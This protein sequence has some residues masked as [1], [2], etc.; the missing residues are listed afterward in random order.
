MKKN[1]T[2]KA[3][4]SIVITTYKRKVEVISKSIQ[5]VL[6]QTYRALE[7]IIVDDSPADYQERE[8]VKKYC[9]GL[10]DPRVRYVQQAKNMG[11]CVAR[12]TGLEMANGQLI[13]FL[14]DD[15]E[16][17]PERIE[18]M[19]PYFK[20]NV[21]LVYSNARII[22]YKKKDFSTTYF[23]TGRQYQ[24]NVYSKIM[25]NNFVGSTS[26]AMLKTEKLRQVGG[27]DPEMPAFQDWDVWIRMSKEG[28]F[29]YTEEPLVNYYIYEGERITNNTAKRLA[30]LHRLNEK[31]K[32]YISSSNNVFV[33]RKYYEMR[34]NIRL[35]NVKKAIKL[36][37]V[38][39]QHQRNKVFAN[40]KILKSF[41]RLFIEEKI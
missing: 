16:Y 15:D 30:A 25:E 31:N 23:D 10:N 35:K 6:G 21:V 17:L 38:I 20:E 32:E 24:G 18:K 19:V 29:A 14:D 2:N 1:V 7:L 4:V 26:V 39:V 9:E 5:S 12:N 34:L 41:G 11:A 22:N 27:F 36:Y 40:L 13:A 33:A 3:L 37:R 8:S 28:D